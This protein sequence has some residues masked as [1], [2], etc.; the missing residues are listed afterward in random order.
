MA[1]VTVEGTITPSTF[2]ATGHRL[3]I[4]CTPYIE[5]L[6]RRG[7]VKVVS[8]DAA[9]A[10][11]PERESEPAPTTEDTAAVEESMPKR[12]E[13]EMPARN[14]RRDVW[15]EFLD[16][17]GVA[18]ADTDTRDQLIDRWISVAGEPADG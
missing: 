6:I 9:P 12:R 17:Q 2:L 15:V 4:E 14:A 7:Y 16:Q 8:E 10:A 13:P 11:T 1:R 18:Y 3:T 5:K